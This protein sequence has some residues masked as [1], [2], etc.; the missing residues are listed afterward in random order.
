MRPCPRAVEAIEDDD[1]VAAA[2]ADYHAT[3]AAIRAAIPRAGQ[4]ADAL[5]RAM[6]RMGDGEQVLRALARQRA[7]ARAIAEQAVADHKASLEPP[8]AL[9]VVRPT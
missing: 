3:L 4:N 2:L 7:M 8:P 6:W 9:T 1:P 5:V